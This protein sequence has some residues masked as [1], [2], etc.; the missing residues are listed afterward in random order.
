MSSKY[1]TPKCDLCQGH[2]DRKENEVIPKIQDLMKWA[3][4]N[5]YHLK[6]CHD[7]LKNYKPKQIVSQ[8]KMLDDINQNF[9]KK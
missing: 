9:H 6:C 5:H 7:V 1:I 2:I 3:H 8:L 4:I